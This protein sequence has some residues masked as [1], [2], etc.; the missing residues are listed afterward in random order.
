[1]GKRA[2][3][4]P[5]PHVVDDA[6]LDRPRPARTDRAVVV[7]VH[8]KSLRA[9]LD[10]VPVLREICEVLPTLPGVLLQVDVHPDVLDPS[11]ADSRRQAFRGWADEVAGRGDV[12]LRVHDR[13][14]DDDLAGYLAA[15]DIC[16]LP[17][18]FGTHSGWLEACVDVGTPVLVPSVGHYADQHG[19]PRYRHP[20]TPGAPPAPPISALLAKAVGDRD[21]ALRRV[22]DRRAQRHRIAEQHFEVY[23]AVLREM[24]LKK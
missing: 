14:T 13:F 9:N 1:M 12:D 8:A 16:V 6:W 15:L 7:G 19:H 20:A 21:F 17:Y 5:H 11:S 3:V 18:R 2:T 10:P 24:T 23:R 22:A 4:V